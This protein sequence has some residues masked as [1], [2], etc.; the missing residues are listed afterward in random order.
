MKFITLLLISLA[1]ITTFANTNTSKTKVKPNFHTK[2]DKAFTLEFLIATEQTKEIYTKKM[3]G[4]YTKFDASLLQHVTKNDEVRYFLSTRY[5]DSKAES[6]GNELE[7][8]FAELMYRRKNILTESSNGLYM[9]A[10]LKNY[11]VID[12]DIKNDYA[13][14]GAIIPQFIFKKNF[15]RVASAKLKVRSHFYQTNSDDNYTL[16][17]EDR[18]YLSGAFMIGRRLLM[19]TQLKYQHKIRKG[20]GWNYRYGDHFGELMDVSF[21]PMTRQMEIDD[22]RIPKA[23]KHQE[24]VTL[25]TGPLFFLSRNSMIEVYAETKLSDTYDKRNLETIAREEFVLGTALYLTA[26]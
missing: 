26:F 12:E 11:R 19:N 2:T 22:S 8:F 20:S 16:E 23:K 9:E 24:I 4:S 10:E 17:K 6:A 18:I 13:Y 25:H 15:G 14:D 21:N 5:V 7:V 1:T 3:D